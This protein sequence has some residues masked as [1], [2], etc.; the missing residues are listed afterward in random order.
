MS[1]THP[2]G[3]AR[4]SCRCGPALKKH[5]LRGNKGMKMIEQP[6]RL[7]SKFISRLCHTGQCFIGFYGILEARQFS[8]KARGKVD[9]IF[10]RHVSFPLS[11]LAEN[12]CLSLF[13]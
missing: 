3:L 5:S 6:D 8:H 12:I 13:E 4:E 1:D 2:P 10:E 11:P 7:K 9:A